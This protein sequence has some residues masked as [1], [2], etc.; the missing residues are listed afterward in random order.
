MKTETKIK[1]A[2]VLLM[3]VSL[4]AGAILVK[5]FGIGWYLGLICLNGVLMMYINHLVTQMGDTTFIIC[6]REEYEEEYAD[7]EEDN[8]DR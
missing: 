1:I 4:I 8:E 7:E 5:G 3:I 2:V 6:D